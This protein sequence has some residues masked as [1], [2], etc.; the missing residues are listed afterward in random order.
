MCVWGGGGGG[1]EDIDR[2]DIDRKAKQVEMEKHGGEGGGNMN[3]MK[4][5]GHL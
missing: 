5:I 2:K 4:C 3:K 1:G